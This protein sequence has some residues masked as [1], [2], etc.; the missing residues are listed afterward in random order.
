MNRRIF[1]WL[2]LIVLAASLLAGCRRNTPQKT[3]EG[4][5]AIVEGAQKS[6]QNAIVLQQQIIQEMKSFDQAVEKWAAEEGLQPENQTIDVAKVVSRMEGR[7]AESLKDGKLIDPT[8][9]PYVILPL[10]PGSSVRIKISAETA[11]K[12]EF[13]DMNWG[14]YSPK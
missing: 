7:L 12:P 11:A 5:H 6:G 3:D 10:D 2:G 9:N 4:G 8:G 1:S 13:K 14:E